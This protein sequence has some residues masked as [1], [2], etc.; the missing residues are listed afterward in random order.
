LVQDA[1]VVM[2]AHETVEW[3]KC[4]RC[5]EFE[6]AHRT[7]GQLQAGQLGGVGLQLRNRLVGDQQAYEPSAVG[8]DHAAYLTATVCLRPTSSDMRAPAKRPMSGNAGVVNRSSTAITICTAVRNTK[9][10][11]KLRVNAN[12]PF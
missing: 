10:P 6:V 4:A 3:R 11:R 8:R 9:I 1:P 7:F 2:A 5:Q 12:R